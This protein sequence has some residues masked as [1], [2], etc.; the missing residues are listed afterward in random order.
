MSAETADAVDPRKRAIDLKRAEIDLVRAK[1]DLKAA[2]RKA[3]REKR[4]ADRAERAALFDL[5]S[6]DFDH[7]L[8]YFNL[9]VDEASVD[10]ARTQVLAYSRM[11]PGEPLTFEINSPGGSVFDGYDLFGVLRE[12]AGNGH[13][14]TTRISG[15]AGSMGGILAQ[16]GDVREIRRHSYLHLHEAASR[17]WGKASAVGDAHK[18]IELMSRQAALIYAER[19]SLS[20]EEIFARMERREWYLTDEEAHKIGFVDRIV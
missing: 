1:V 19:S 16:A 11:Y 10:W 9:E 4:E 15:C 12:A 20:A 13:Q 5:A 14:I 18:L 7:G 6:S 17:A 3:K 2:R 8:I